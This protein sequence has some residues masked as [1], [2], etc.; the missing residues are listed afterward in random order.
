[1]LE[2]FHLL[3][4][5]WWSKKKKIARTKPKKYKLNN[6]KKKKN[7]NLSSTHT[8]LQKNWPIATGQNAAKAQKIAAKG[9]F[10]L[11]Q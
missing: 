1:M 6:Q 2:P 9:P 7:S 3:Q 8:P 4:K 5:Q 11:L 10:G